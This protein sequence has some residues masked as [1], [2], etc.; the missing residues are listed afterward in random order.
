MKI[1]ITGIGGYLGSQLANA[2]I[3]EHELAGTVRS[4]SKLDRIHNQDKVSFIDVDKS[5]WAQQVKQFKPDVVI[6]T[7]AL[8][9]RNGE[10]LTDLIR[11]NI[12]FPMMLLEGLCKEKR[13]TFINCGTSLCPNVSKYALTKNQFVDLCKDMDSPNVKFINI[14][15]EHFFGFGDDDGKFTT[16]LVKSCLK[17]QDLKLTQCNQIRD[18][19]YISDL[20]DAFKVILSRID[21]LDN[22]SQVDVGYGYGITLKEFVN[23]VIRYTAFK[24]D[25]AYGAVPYRKNEV[26]YSVADIS[27][28][29]M[30]GWEPKYNIEKALKEYIEL[31][32]I[33]MFD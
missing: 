28:L 23:A 3:A 16:Y 8:Y 15:L 11:A 27:K 33:S 4:G 32:K 26:M 30:L 5:D 7:A 17:N 19:I 18:F 22:F 31:L 10:L 6:N 14:R 12:L 13:V 21:E 20:L 24:G 29:T 1:L 2:L 9:G 25:V